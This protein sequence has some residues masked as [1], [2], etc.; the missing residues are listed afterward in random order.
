MK[1][2]D[3]SS[4]LQ[5]Y[6]QVPLWLLTSIT[7]RLKFYVSFMWKQIL[8]L[9]LKILLLIA[10]KSSN[11]FFLENCT[12]CVMVC[13]S[14][15]GIITCRA[16]TRG[17]QTKPVSRLWWCSSLSSSSRYSRDLPAGDWRWSVCVDQ[18]WWWIWTP[19]HPGVQI[20]HD[21][22]WLKQRLWKMIV[23]YSELFKVQWL[24]LIVLM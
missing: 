20:L 5:C 12:F 14:K 4:I 2:Y 13:V 3:V 19:W 7:L 21:I 15:Y 10:L 23:S 11:I 9:L 16:M 22:L 1:V 18:W 17:G 8:V 6:I 24:I